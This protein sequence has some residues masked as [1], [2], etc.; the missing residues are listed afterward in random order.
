MIDSFSPLTRRILAVGL[1]VLALLVGLRLIVL[2]AGSVGAALDRLEDSRFA[3]ARV[4]A[5][6]ARPLPPRSP[7]L[8]PGQFLQAESHA[9]AADAAAARIRD[10]AT[11]NT[12]TLEGITPVPQDPANPR[13][14]RLSFAAR[15]AEPAL[16]AFLQAVERDGPPLR[17]QG[18]SIGRGSPDSP[19]LNLQ[20]NAA[21]AWSAAP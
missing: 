11:Q 3:L 19:D 7:P 10:A 5:V 16:L 17:L 14:V 13:L 8:S 2:V 21:I 4:E 9:V 12:V 18:W 15:A 6:R 1:L 20:A